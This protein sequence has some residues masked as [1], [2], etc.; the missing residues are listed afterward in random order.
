MDNGVFDAQ[1][2]ATE[3][4]NG[5]RRIVKVKEHPVQR[6]PARDNLIYLLIANRLAE[7][8]ESPKNL[9]ASSLKKRAQAGYVLVIGTTIRKA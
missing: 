6:V 7:D 1:A 3:I 8:R 2:L 5:A 9:A 4:F